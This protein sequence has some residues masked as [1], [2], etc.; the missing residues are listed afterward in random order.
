MECKKYSKEFIPGQSSQ[1]SIKDL[2]MQVLRFTI[3]LVDAHRRY[4]MI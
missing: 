4:E 2:V 1:Q 3:I